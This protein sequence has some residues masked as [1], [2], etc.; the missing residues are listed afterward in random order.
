MPPSGRVVQGVNDALNVVRI[1][2]RQFVPVDSRKSTY[3]GEVTTYELVQLLLTD[4]PAEDAVEVDFVLGQLNVYRHVGLGLLM[5]EP[6]VTMSLDMT[7]LGTEGLALHM[8]KFNTL[9]LKTREHH[10]VTVLN[11]LDFHN[12]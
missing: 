5:E 3:K 7:Q 12:R 2:E 11:L 4:E 1:A 8:L 9:L 6:V 10:I